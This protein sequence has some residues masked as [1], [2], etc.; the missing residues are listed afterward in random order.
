MTSAISEVVKEKITAVVGV[1]AVVIG[2]GA[3]LPTM[4]TTLASVSPY[5]PLLNF[6]LIATLISIG[7]FLFILEVF[8]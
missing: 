8:L 6:S 3:L 4:Q 2:V 7:I 5:A 1:L